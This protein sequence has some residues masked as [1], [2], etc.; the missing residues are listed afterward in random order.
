[1]NEIINKFG[2][3]RKYEIIY[4]YSYTEIEDGFVQMNN[5]NG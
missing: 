3:L 5:N 2:I 1:M 4:K